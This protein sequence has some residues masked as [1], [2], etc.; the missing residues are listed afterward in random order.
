MMPTTQQDPSTSSNAAQPSLMNN[1]AFMTIISCRCLVSKDL[2]HSPMTSKGNA[3]K[4]KQPLA[5]KHAAAAA[6]SAYNGA[7]HDV[8]SAMP[9]QQ[10][11]NT[12]SSFSQRA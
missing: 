4:K 6:S 11:S 8:S 7:H 12:L 5:I 9:T 10:E 3:S 1:N 2:D